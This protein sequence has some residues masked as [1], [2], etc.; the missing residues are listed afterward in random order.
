LNRARDVE[1]PMV[2]FDTLALWAA[3]IQISAINH[4]R[5]QTGIGSAYLRDRAAGLPEL[6]ATTH[7]TV[8]PRVAAQRFR[9]P[10]LRVPEVRLHQ[11]Y[12][13]TGRSLELKR[14]G[15]ARQ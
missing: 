8:E 2:Q 10:D 12:R 7:A 11:Y 15:L 6:P 3:R 1:R 13:R 5:I 4:A 9:H 14:G